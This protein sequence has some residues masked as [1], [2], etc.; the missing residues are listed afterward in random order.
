MTQASQ[1]L[2]LLHERREGDVPE[3]MDFF[4]RACSKHTSKRAERCPP[5]IKR[6]QKLFDLNPK[7]THEILLEMW[8]NLNVLFRASADP[9]ITDHEVEIPRISSGGSHPIRTRFFC[10]GP[11]ES[12]LPRNM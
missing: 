12:I 7:A 11:L 10:P 6:I 9:E 4:T 5:A 3:M 2:L 1:N 8:V